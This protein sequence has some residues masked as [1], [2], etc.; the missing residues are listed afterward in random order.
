[1]PLLFSIPVFREDIIRALSWT[2]IHS[3]WQG[4]LLAMFAAC[5]VFF[6]K[7]A[8]PALRYNLL[9]GALLIFITGVLATFSSQVISNAPIVP[10]VPEIPASTMISL[11]PVITPLVAENKLSIADKA[12]EYFNANAAWIVLTWLFIILLRC[13]RLTAGL[14]GV[15]QLK[16]RQTISPGEYWNNRIT[17]LSRQL[18]INKRVT[19]LQSG[20]SGLPAVIG[21]FKPVILFPAGMLASLPTDEVEAILVHELAHI[22]RK[23]FLVNLVQHIVEIIFFFNPAVRWVSCLIKSERENCCDDIA[24]SH[25]DNKRNYINALIAFQG[26]ELQLASPL[27]NAFG[28]EK[29]HLMNRVKRII[30]KNNKTLNNMEKKFLAAGMIITSIFIFAF[31]SNNLRHT[32]LET[33]TTLQNK[34]IPLTEK[35]PADLVAMNDTVPDRDLERKDVL[36]GTINSSLNGRKYK[37]VT[38]NDQVS[39]LYVN[40]KKIPA[41]KIAGYKSV[42]DKILLQAKVDMVQSGKDQEESRADLAES[43]KDRMRAKLEMEKEQAEMAVEMEQQRK[44]MAE[45]MEQSKK[46][47]EVQKKVMDRDMEQAKKEQEML[48][49]K[50]S[51]IEMEQAKLEMEQAKKNMDRDMEQAKK[52]MERVKIEME[53]DMKQAKIEM[54]QVKKDLARSKSEMVQSRK[55]ME[56]SRRDMEESKKMQENVIADFIKENLIKD[57]KELFSY[58]LSNEELIVNGVK[59]P[60]AIHQRFKDKY[61]SGNNR[62]M[63]Y[64][65]SGEVK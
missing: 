62:T 24:V 57:K 36:N 9:T 27:T 4:M 13:A 45:E 64:N 19:L 6:T 56:Q 48:T 8:A 46:E 50:E 44:E 23:D 47:M 18:Q 61:V 49:T 65:N 59:Q 29:N 7:K 14:Y 32:T 34:D 35:A 10:G 51:K 31:S 42:T 15:Y 20:M 11:Q 1:M 39:E 60:D 17:E 58:K 41:E 33:N 22:R 28:G 5:V 40:G 30:Y 12:V 3:L 54:E 37:I 43:E 63:Q 16:R 25:T 21:Y 55:E 26:F 52:E 38:K 2:L 53:R